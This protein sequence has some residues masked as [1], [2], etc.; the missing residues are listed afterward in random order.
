MKLNG[1]LISLL[2]R[3]IIS[4]IKL[5]VNTLKFPIHHYNYGY[6]KLDTLEKTLNRQI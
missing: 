4:V 1:V 6:L 2:S 3:V 5:F